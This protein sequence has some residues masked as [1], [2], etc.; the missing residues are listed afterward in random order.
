ML[1]EITRTVILAKYI[2]DILLYLHNTSSQLLRSGAIF[3]DIFGKKNV[4]YKAGITI[5]RDLPYTSN[6]K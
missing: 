5:D 6:N 1:L 2:A 4:T 3:G